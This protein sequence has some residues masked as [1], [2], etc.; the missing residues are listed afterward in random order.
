VVLF[1]IDFPTWLAQTQGLES[2][3]A[4]KNWMFYEVFGMHT[5]GNTL[6]E[7]PKKNWIQNGLSTVGFFGGSTPLHGAC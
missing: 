3:R 1:R 7:T 4:K 6:I 5:V 2:Q